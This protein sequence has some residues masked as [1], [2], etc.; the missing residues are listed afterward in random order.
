MERNEKTNGLIAVALVMAIL[1][2][3]SIIAQNGSSTN[4]GSDDDSG[5]EDNETNKGS[6]DIPD[7][8][9][10]GPTN[11]PIAEM[12]Y[13]LDI[14][15]QRQMTED[16]SAVYKFTFTDPHKGCV[17]TNEVACAAVIQS[18]TYELEFEGNDDGL[19]GEFSEV[20]CT[21]SEETGACSISSLN[22]EF[23]MYEQETKVIQ[24]TVTAEKQGT[25]NFLVQLKGEGV[26]AYGK[27]ALVYID[28]GV[29]PEEETAFFVGKGFVLSENKTNGFLLD[30]KILNKDSVLSG[31]AKIGD[32]NYKIE[33]QVAE[34]AVDGVDFGY[35]S[36]YV[37][38]DLISI[39]TGEKVGSFE[40]YARQYTGFILLEGKI[41]NFEGKTW[42]L[43]AMGK[44]KFEVR[45]FD[46][47]DG[48]SV[49]VSV[50]EAVFVPGVTSVSTDDSL[51]ETEDEVYIKPI[52]V[53]E[54]R[55]LWI[56][57]TSKKVVEIEVVKGDEVFKKKITEYSYEN[58]EGYKVSV[59]SLEDDEKIE[60]DV[61]KA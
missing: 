52:K 35:T 48:E 36:S 11:P 57:Q 25:H 12:P 34:V 56:F 13:R 39:K 18:Y 28:N 53:K 60:F 49:E 32:R 6:D 30:L 16:G 8:T 9:D 33:G 7:R 41:K 3:G 58:V 54:K 40:G 5:R 17:S 47:D 38:F 4:N 37:T 1:M 29:I 42:T 27:G 43:T 61:E 22:D 14:D 21:G 59:G 31:K 2:L 24:L 10:S 50:G 55:V 15:P 26:K 23:E 19:N 51:D 20:V 46:L 45:E 44:K